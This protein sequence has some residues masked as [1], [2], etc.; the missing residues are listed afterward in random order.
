V[1]STGRLKAFKLTSVAGAY[2]R[3]SERNEMLQRIYGTGVRLP[4]E[5]KT[6]LA[7]LE[8]AKRAITVVSARAEPVQL[9]PG[10]AGESVL[11]TRRAR[12]STT[13]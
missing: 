5:L 2:W 1:P 8:E 3:G 4:K 10:S 7:M 12:S 11:S 6:H 9:P 13:S